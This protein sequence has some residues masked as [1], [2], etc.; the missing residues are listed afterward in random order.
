[1]NELDRSKVNKKVLFSRIF[2]ATTPLSMLKI[3]FQLNII[4]N[5]YTKKLI[6]SV[7]TRNSTKFKNKWYCAIIF[8]LILFQ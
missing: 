5:I 3:M 1:M 2:S 4:Q 6:L 7:R 8:N